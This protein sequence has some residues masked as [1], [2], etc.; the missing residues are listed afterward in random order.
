MENM[1]SA[2]F[3]LLCCL[4]AL[5]LLI[6]AQYASYG[7]DYL[8]LLRG[9]GG[10]LYG[11]AYGLIQYGSEN[12]Y[13]NPARLN[14][15]SDKSLYL[16]H[17][18]WFRNEVT[19]SSAA[20]NFQLKDRSVGI[21]ISRIGI[22]DVPDSRNALLDY[23]LDGIPGTGDTGEGNGQLDQNEIIDYDG[24]LFTGIANYAVHLGMPVYIKNNLLVGLDVGFLYTGLI[25]TNGYGLTFDLHA[26]HRGAHVQSLY[27]IKNLPS[28]M[29]VFSNGSAQYYLPQLKAAWLLPFKAGNL[30]IKPGISTAMSFAQ[31]LDYYMIPIGS[32]MALDIQ[33]LVQISYHDLISLGISYKY[34]DGIHAGIEF[35]VPNLDI[36]YSFRPSQGSDLGSSHLVSL[37]LSTDIFK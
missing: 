30:S 31:D 6:F 8:N 20:F 19:A 37:R 34:G 18:S 13:L 7:N 35:S 21:M 26:E 12:T 27:S 16:Y 10:E 17:S 14:D 25:E 5:P 36:S 23:G 4:L 29:M 24:V 9:P 1:R 11:Q 3:V 32:F 33:P 28:A 22:T 2:K 15:H